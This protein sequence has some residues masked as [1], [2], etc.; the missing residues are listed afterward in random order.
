[1][2][3]NNVANANTVGFKQGGACSPTCTRTRSP[4]AAAAP[5]SASRS[6]A[7]QQN[8]SQGNVSTTSNPLD[9]AING[10][11][12]FRMDTNGTVSYSRN[13]QFHLD[14][15]GF[16]VNATGSKVTGYGVDAAGNVLISDAG[17]C[18]SRSPAAGDAPRRRADRPQPRLR[19][20]RSSRRLRR[21]PIP[22]TLQQGDVD[23]GLRQPRQPH[24]F[25]PTTQ[26]R[27]EHLDR[28]RRDRRTALPARS[29]AAV[30]HRRHARR[31]HAALPFT[32]RSPSPTARPR[33]SRSR[34]TTGR[35]AVR[36]P[37]GVNTLQQDGFSSGS[38]RASRSAATA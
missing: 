23:D 6:T 12:F 16:I 25:T 27:G 7:I 1:V 9:V 17:R 24:A 30:R 37:F 22:T 34:S 29:A 35:D 28:V 20:N 4:A 8:F 14:K 32:S 2:I 26:D 5:A 31:R 18:R 15:D 10:S 33:R 13:G 38:C 21:S 19:A 3:G 11:G 36:Q